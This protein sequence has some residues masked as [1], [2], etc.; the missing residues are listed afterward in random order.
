[1]IQGGDFERG[2]GTGGV[3]IYGSKVRAD[4]VRPT[5]RI[6]TRFLLGTNADSPRS[7]TTRSLR[8]STT[9]SISDRPRVYITDDAE[10]GL[11]SSANSGPNTNGSQ[12]FITTADKCEWLEC[13]MTTMCVKAMADMWQ[14]EARRVWGSGQR[15]GRRQGS[16]EARQQEWPGLE[17]EQDHRQ[18]L[19]R[20]LSLVA[21]GTGEPMHV[22]ELSSKCIK[23]DI[24]SVYK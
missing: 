2:D 20:R 17:L 22:P 9:A 12:F 11:L 6:A 16:G 7:L 10:A 21:V 23:V 24:L 8:R 14:R 19:W 18:G 13:V 15:D 1:M 3:S 4:S 5:G